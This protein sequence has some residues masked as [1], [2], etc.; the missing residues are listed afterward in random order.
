MFLLLRHR[1]VWILRIDPV[2]CS[3]HFTGALQVMIFSAA[4]NRNPNSL[5]SRLRRKRTELFAKLL[6]PFHEP[7]R[8]LDVGGTASFWVNN[9]PSLPKQCHFTLLNLEL[10]ST[11]GLKNA[12]SLVGDARETGLEDNEFDIVFSNSVIEHV[13]TLYD[14]MA[15]AKEVQRV[16][17]SFFLQTPNRYFPLEPHFLCPFWQFL[18]TWFRAALHR[19]VRLGWMNR[20]PDALLARAGV[21]QVRL[22]THYEMKRLFGDAQIHTETIGPLTKSLIAVRPQK[23]E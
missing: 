20:E 13:G 16:A 12:C 17:K 14:Q 1:P 2:H 21:E 7:V 3:R 10:E 23:S 5:A 19:R 11:G 4:D 9:A 22:L 15:M 18:P 8:I 6:E